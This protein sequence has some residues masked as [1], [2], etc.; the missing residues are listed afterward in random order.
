MT[1]GIAKVIG[2]YLRA[3]GKKEISM[4]FTMPDDATNVTFDLGGVVRIETIRLGQI[5]NKATSSVDIDHGGK[6][7]SLK[8]NQ[9]KFT[10]VLDDGGIANLNLE[11]F[12]GV[13]I[14][15]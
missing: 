9:I 5:A 13:I 8:P 6:N 4:R 2:T 12:E 3:D 11:M 1:D 7:G 14:G 15:V 10:N